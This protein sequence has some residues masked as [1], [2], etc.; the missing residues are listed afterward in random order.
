MLEFLGGLIM[1]VGQM[2]VILLKEAGDLNPS[3]RYAVCCGPNN[4]WFPA[5][6]RFS[7]KEAAI[8]DAPECYPKRELVEGTE[9]ITL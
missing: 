4:N 7:S 8:K 6:E 2:K 9:T 3:W 5:P 1:K